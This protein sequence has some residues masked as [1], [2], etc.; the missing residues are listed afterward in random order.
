M[1]TRCWNL[2]FREGCK[3]GFTG[4]GYEAYAKDKKQCRV[5]AATKLIPWEA[6]GKQF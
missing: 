5:H 2:K 6:L 4:E 1:F 3:E